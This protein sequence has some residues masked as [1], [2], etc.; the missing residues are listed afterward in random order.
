MTTASHST[1]SE[2]DHPNNELDPKTNLLTIVATKFSFDHLMNWNYETPFDEWDGIRVEN[3]DEVVDLNGDE[4]PLKQS[5]YLHDFGS[6]ILTYRLVV[7]KLVGRKIRGDLTCL[8]TCVNMRTLVLNDTKVKGSLEPLG[9][10]VELRRLNL[11][12][13]KVN[14]S[15][16]PLKNCIQLQTILLSDTKVSGNIDTFE[17]CP[18]L[19]YCKLDYTN[20]FGP[21]EVFHKCPELYTLDLQHTEVTGNTAILRFAAPNCNPREILSLHQRLDSDIN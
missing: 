4:L 17:S 15:I 2:L 18:F 19:E 20:V 13:S 11:C 7:L 6:S 12:R 1:H 9:N 16:A 10:L 21:V 8:E 3:N 5:L 14:G